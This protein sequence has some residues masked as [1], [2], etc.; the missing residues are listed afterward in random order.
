[1]NHKLI[2]SIFIILLLLA[3]IPFSFTATPEPYLFGWLPFPL[4]FWWVLMIVNLF[5]VLWVANTF[6]KNAEKNAKEDKQ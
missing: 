6:T 2:V 1:M 3:M 4:M 5:F